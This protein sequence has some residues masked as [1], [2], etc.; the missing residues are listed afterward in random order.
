M[1]AVAVAAFSAL[2]AALLT[3]HVMH[4]HAVLDVPNERSSH[5]VPTPR[6]GG[7]AVVGVIVAA[8]GVFAAAR[9]IS[10]PEALAL[11]GAVPVALAGWFDDRH[12]LPVRLR[13]VTHV[14]AAI[15]ALICLGGLPAVRVGDAELA[16]GP[17]GWA[18]GVLGIVWA[19]NFY[20]FM[21]GIDGIAGTQALAAGASA[22]LLLGLAGAPG[23]AVT[24]AALA[25]AAFGFLR[26]NWHPARIFLGDVGSG[27]L[28]YLV[29][30]LGIASEQAGAVPLLS[31]VV[32]LGPF[33]TDATATL[34]RRLVRGERVYQA[35]RSHA[36]QRLVRAGW[37]HA[38]VAGAYGLAAASMAVP[39]W[40][41]W[42]R[43]T[44]GVW[45]AAA[46]ALALVAAYAAV[47][48][49]QPLAASR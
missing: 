2:G 28:G 16:L 49:V 20:N 22:A 40:L 26:W 46:A 6:G 41:L 30:V 8:V 47:E 45:A 32:L 36:Y 21:D 33:V 18:L 42:A 44:L 29:A 25:G 48:R 12:T 31:F 7:L 43:P 27:T 10:V 15:W 34:V 14:G 37:S 23:L 24:A 9:L 3:W 19:I 17:A 35:H 11:A 4:R 5:A 13:L 39:A 38:T 1:L